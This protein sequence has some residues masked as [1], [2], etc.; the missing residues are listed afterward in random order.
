M[1]PAAGGGELG[2][3]P[4]KTPVWLWVAGSVFVGL[5]IVVLAASVTRPEPVVFGLSP[6]EARD[7]PHRLVGPDTVTIDGRDGNR[8]VHFDLG[9][10]A[11]AAA[12]EDWDIAVKRYRLVAN[13]GDGL[14]G[15]GGV[16]RVEAPF[17]SVRE[18]PAIGYETSRVTPGRD[19]VNVVLD[20]WYSYS[21]LSHLLQ[22][23]RATFVVRTHDG[24]YAKLAVLAYYC[25]GPEPGCLTIEYAYQGDGTRRLVPVEP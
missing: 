1:R 6:L 24:R 7:A 22:P 17:D 18:A 13:G 21:W 9:R 16:V 10:S 25:P 5:I 19:T 11:V 20:D 15:E 14:A 2:T 4:Q 8:W 23:D 12:G 3:G